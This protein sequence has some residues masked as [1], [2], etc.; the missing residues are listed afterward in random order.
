[1]AKQSL[2]KRIAKCL[3]NRPILALRY[4]IATALY[5]GT[6]AKEPERVAA[7]KG[8]VKIDFLAFLGAF[9]TFYLCLK[10]LACKMRK[11]K[12]KK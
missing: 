12:N 7:H 4:R 9:F 8:A 10:A 2:P 5:R 11:R 3:K 6:S 1:M